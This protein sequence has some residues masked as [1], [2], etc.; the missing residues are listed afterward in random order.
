M[1]RSLL[2][3]PELKNRNHDLDSPEATILHGKIIQSKPFLKKLY[4]QW[5]AFFVNKTKNVPEGIFLELGSGSGYIKEFLPDTITTDVLDLPNIDKWMSAEDLQFENETLSAIFMIDV[6]HHIP[7]PELFFKEAQ[8]CLKKG[9]KIVL[10]EPANSFWGRF[11]YTNFHH[12]PFNPKGGWE[13]PSIGPMSGANGAIPWIILER[14]RTLFNE[15]FP[16]LNIDMIKYHTPFR[17]LLSGGV[18]MKSL[19]PSWSFGVLSAFDSLIAFVSG[20]SLS[21]FQKIVITKQ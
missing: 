21:M 4:N 9:G 18:S 12:E 8:R 17:Y 16:H 13:T 1:L 10:I 3:I 2:Q 15:K 6:L 19:V 11:I 7:H 20:G 14:D 5:Y